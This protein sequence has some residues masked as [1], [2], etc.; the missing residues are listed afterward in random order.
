MEWNLL[1]FANSVFLGVGLA[2]DAFSVSVANGI[3]DTQ[4]KKSKDFK[5]AGTFG[6]FQW[7]MPVLG[8]ILVHTAAE[9]FE[10]FQKLVPY[11]ALIL[12]SYIGGK[13]IYDAKKHKGEGESMPELSG[14]TL[15]IQGIATSIDALSVGFT[16]VDYTWLPVVVQA[17]I[18]ATVTFFIC[19]A[20]CKIGKKFSEKFMDRSQYVGGTI[21]I[22]IGLEIF[23][24]SFF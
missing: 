6:F 23:I 5:I 4:K 11:I 24:K 17:V 1:F 14:V 3:G 21:L 18:V 8:W 9:K 16:N 13:M 15:F 19:I 10:I 7:L 22:L 20:G 12:L 2:M